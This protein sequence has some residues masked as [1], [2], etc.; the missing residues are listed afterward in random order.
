MKKILVLLVMVTSFLALCAC[1]T[2][3]TMP[4]KSGVIQESEVI[5]D[6]S[7]ILND[8]KAILDKKCEKHADYII[9]T[10]LVCSKNNSYDY[11][12]HLDDKCTQ[13]YNIM[14]DILMSIQKTVYVYD[15]ILF[16]DRIA[17]CNGSEYTINHTYGDS[18][19]NRDGNTFWEWAPDGVITGSKKRK[20]CQFIKERY[21]YYDN[22]YGGYSGDRFSD[23]IM[24]E[25]A[26]KYGITEQEAFIIWC[27]M[28]S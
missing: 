16:I 11:F 17:V 25:A 7:T 22:L 27:N 21:A 20:I 13:K 9:E 1:S 18:L 15:E 23:T 4:Q 3:N 8:A 19:I 5:V 10:Q 2:S 6:A 14:Y 28:Y 26:D 12:V 24:Q